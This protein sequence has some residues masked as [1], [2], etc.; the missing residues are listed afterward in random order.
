M[1]SENFGFVNSVQE[2]Y[3]LITEYETNHTVKF[4]CYKADKE[5]GNTGKG[6]FICIYIHRNASASGFPILC[7]FLKY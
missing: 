7:Y 3:K 6:T 2:A 1:I 5:F 4:A